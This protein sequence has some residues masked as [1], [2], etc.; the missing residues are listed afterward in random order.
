MTPKP[1]KG[2]EVS[3]DKKRHLRYPLATLRAITD[4]ADL[5]TILHLGLKWEDENLTEEEV[6]EIV[7]LEMLHELADPLKKATGGLVDVNALLGIAADEASE[8][9]AEGN[10]GEKTD[11]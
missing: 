4:D 10:D 7:D 2:V 9:G 5:I 8:G 11:G 3:L 1:T 6:G